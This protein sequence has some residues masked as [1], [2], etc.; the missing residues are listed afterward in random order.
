MDNLN[1]KPK[2][3]VSQQPK[4]DAEPVSAPK[5]QVPKTPVSSVSKQPK[6]SNS[7]LDSN[8]TRETIMKQGFAPKNWKPG[9]QTSGYTKISELNFNNPYRKIRNRL[10]RIKY[11]QYPF[12]RFING[13]D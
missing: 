9:D 10:P 3:E 4:V 5:Q 13:Q 6:I 12:Q 8:Q 2:L 11:I 1:K 7:T